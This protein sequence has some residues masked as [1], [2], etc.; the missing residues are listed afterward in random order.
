MFV[1]FLVFGL[2][3]QL[4]LFYVKDVKIKGFR[5]YDLGKAQYGIHICTFEDVIVEDAIIKGD[6]DG[7]HFGRGKRFLVSNCV[8]ETFDDAIAL[9]GHDYDVGNPELG[10]IENGTIE[11]CH[12]LTAEKTTGFFCRIL[13]GAWV[14]WQK[15]MVVQK[16]DTV[17][18]CGRLY[19]VKAA[20]DGKQYISETQPTH[21]QE[22]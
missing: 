12:D 11:N 7:V 22:K 3:G 20:P 2:H 13:A 14:D 9:N 18:S 6:K 1:I 21:E 17:V 15:G 16:S 19:R 10:W 5:C 4:A 8:F